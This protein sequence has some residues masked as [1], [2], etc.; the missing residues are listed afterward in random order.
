MSVERN[1]INDAG[2]KLK[3]HDQSHSHIHENIHDHSHEH[4]GASV[5]LKIVP[6]KT[7][8]ANKSVE[9][10]EQQ[11]H[12][13]GVEILDHKV[14]EKNL[15]EGV[16][17][18]EERLA[19]AHKL[20]I[21]DHKQLVQKDQHGKEHKFQIVEKQVDHKIRIAVLEVEG[22]T[23][24]LC[25][26]GTVDKNGKFEVAPPANAETKSGTKAGA[27]AKAESESHASA[28]HAP[29]PHSETHHLR[30]HSHGGHH[31]SSSHNFSADSNSYAASAEG[32][33]NGN[34]G[35]SYATAV[36]SG[37][38][39]AILDQAASMAPDK[40]TMLP[41]GMVYLRSKLDVDA[42]G[43]ANWRQD[44]VGQATTSLRN[45]DGSSLD[46]LHANYFVLPMTD[47]YKKLGIKLGDLA[48]VR[49]SHTGKMVAA[50]FGDQGPRNKIGE[51]SQA[52]CR[53]LGLSAN[54]NS[55][56]TAEK[57]IE[58]LIMPGSG[59][60]KGNIA[61]DDSAMASRLAS[62]SGSDSNRPGSDASPAA[63]RILACARQ[64]VGNKL[65]QG[66][67]AE[68]NNGRLGCAV[69]TY[70]VLN[71]AGLDNNLQLSA[72]SL[73]EDLERQHWVKKPLSMAQPGDVIYGVKPGTNAQRGGGNAHVGIVSD[74]GNGSNQLMVYANV[75][76]TGEWTHESASR[77]FSANRFGNQVWAYSPP[78]VG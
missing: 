62:L 6:E 56:G 70:K 75:S 31:H 57:E 36:G 22:K 69:S 9:H 40:L 61:K 16:H 52:L 44:P 34:Y 68:T 12:L 45:S 50:I 10:I 66:Y 53:A 27:T 43:G 25:L 42:D 76:K 73:V 21:L 3:S 51:G 35:G 72:G 7:H 18:P 23:A 1:H 5:H 2:A 77:A 41:N 14:L 59:N 47:D 32:T 60:G 48:W 24:R 28:V 49:N 67:G 19:A 8:T 20:F 46:A 30:R 26:D 15:F 63:A 65:W 58:F 55:G 54:P 78:Q 29:Q 71:A 33:N 39:G 38:A 37:D 11:K 17:K 13:P 64:E 4:S 74:G